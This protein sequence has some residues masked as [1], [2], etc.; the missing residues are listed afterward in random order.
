MTTDQGDIEFGEVQAAQ[1]ERRLR[2]DRNRQFCTVACGL[3]SEDELPIFVDL[4]ALGDMEAHALSDTRVELGGV[5]LGGQYEDDRG[6]PFVV[7]ADTLRARHYESTPGSFK[8]THETWAEFTR[9]RGDL[10]PDLQMVGWY[11]THPHLGVFLSDMDNF[12][13][14]HFF[15][16]PGDV[17]LVID[18]C[19]GKRGFFQWTG[20]VPNRTKRCGGFYV[21]AS[22]HREWELTCFAAYLEGRIMGANDPRSGVNPFPGTPY[23]VPPA[24]YADPRGAWFGLAVLGMLFIQFLLLA[25]LGWKTLV[26]EPKPMADATPPLERPVGA[27][28]GE[29]AGAADRLS[30]EAEIQLRLL[31]RIVDQLG[32]GTPQG[33]VRLLEQLQQEN[34]TMKADARVYRA[35]ETKVKA[36]NEAL[37]RAL[38]AAEEDKS[39]LGRQVARLQDT[40][41]EKERA[42]DEYRRKIASLT[43]P[44]PSGVPPEPTSEPRNWTGQSKTLALAGIGILVAGAV[45]WVVLAARKRQREPR[46]EEEA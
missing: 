14:E 17:A 29:A 5:V 16:G 23:P 22:R 43:E 44:A 24:P 3:P 45:G 39:E 33:L 32:Q 26:P 46:T 10:P 30:R 7:I 21:F 13:C 15:N 4:D 38:A 9:Q 27:A 36:D 28:D 42:A 40:V 8:F 12:I 18:P 41:R 2:P 34:E 25:L 31:D 37:S 35:L 6:R 1:C 19:Q 11:H 20:E